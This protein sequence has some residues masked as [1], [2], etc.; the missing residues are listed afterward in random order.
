[1]R[2]DRARARL[3]A[4]GN[5]SK[6]A[7]QDRPLVSGQPRLVPQRAGRCLPARAPGHR[8][9]LRPDPMVHILVTGAG[10]QLG[11]SLQDLAA[12]SPP[13][14]IMTFADRQALDISRADRIAT[15]LA[16]R[17]AD[18]VINA[19]AYTAVDRAAAQPSEA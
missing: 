5:L 13:T 1:C 3:E 10:G 4:A 19:A 15:W 14:A 7:A 11:R 17:P 16:D 9:R 8:R 2:Q 12:T 6:R 18:V